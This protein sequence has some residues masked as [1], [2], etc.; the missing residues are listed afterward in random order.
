MTAY[1]INKVC[2]LSERN[3][4]FREKLRADPEDGLARFGLR[5]DDEERRALLAV[6]WRRCTSRGPPVP[7]AAPGSAR[8][9]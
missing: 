6:M 9:V 5:L 8:L 1:A 3:E 7:D 2:W 4:Q